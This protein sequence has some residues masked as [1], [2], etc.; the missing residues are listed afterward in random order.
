MSWFE[1]KER[2][3][4]GLSEKRDGKTVKKRDTLRVHFQVASL[5]T[6]PAINEVTPIDRSATLQKGCALRDLEVGEIPVAEESVLT[7]ALTLA[8][9]FPHIESTDYVDE[10]WEKV[11]DTI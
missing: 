6:P 8:L 4:L 7:I 11:V 3:R 9:I 1:G 5:C 10:N 2:G